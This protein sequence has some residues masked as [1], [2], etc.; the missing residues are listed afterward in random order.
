[1]DINLYASQAIGTVTYPA[2]L[3]LIVSGSAAAGRVSSALTRLEYVMQGNIER[4][5]LSVGALSLDADHVQRRA[6]VDVW[7]GGGTANLDY[8]AWLFQGQVA[9]P[10]STEDVLVWE[11][12]HGV[13]LRWERIPGANR[14]ISLT[15]N[16]LVRISWA[17]ATVCDSYTDTNNAYFGFFVNETLQAHHTR[18]LASCSIVAPPT[19]RVSGYQGM[20]LMSGVQWVRLP[21][22]VHNVGVGVGSNSS[23]P[24]VRVWAR[25][26][27]I[28][29]Y[30]A[31]DDA[32][33]DT[34]PGETP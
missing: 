16:S 28:A 7:T 24:N 3:P 12:Q 17:V 11:E 8:G 20:R 13:P 30:K 29:A 1:M 4:A 33:Y 22:G 23:I 34:Y 2:V 6:L 27:T 21:A 19:W 26:I 25:N 14:A 32:Y 15:H 18:L 5:N 31:A 9:I 10:T